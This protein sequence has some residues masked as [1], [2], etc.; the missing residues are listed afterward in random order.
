[1]MR[2][3]DTSPPQGSRMPDNGVQPLHGFRE[4]V[5][6]DTEPSHTMQK[7]GND[8]VSVLVRASDKYAS[9]IT[10][11][12][13]TQAYQLLPVDPYRKRALII[14]PDA[15]PGNN[16]PVQSLVVANP[17]AGAQFSAN[18]SPNNPFS[19]VAVAYTLTTSA[20]VANRLAMLNLGALP[21]MAPIVQAASTGIAY[22]FAQGVPSQHI[23]S[24]SFTT[25]PIP[26]NALLLAAG[27]L[28]SSS[29]LSM[30]VADQISAIT[31][32]YTSEIQ[33]GI[34]IGSQPTV[35]NGVGYPLFQDNNL[36]PLE[37]TSK[38]ALYAKAS[39]AGI[40][41][42]ALLVERFNDGT[43]VN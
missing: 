26:G 9:I 38:A 34:V 6:E 3:F 20:A 21:F 11:I 25:V 12:D 28:I 37:Y 32:Y 43:P 16:N 2:G 15:I 40:I 24:T 41:Q 10:A 23:T 42:I 18:P 4:A 7:Q 31:I 29:I 8:G 19:V 27:T 39:Q 33:N 35:D 13:N 14:L 22:T 5:T 1:M 36:P 17:A 30:D